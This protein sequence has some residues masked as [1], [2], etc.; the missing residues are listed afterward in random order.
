MGVSQGYLIPPVMPPNA[1]IMGGIM[2]ASDIPHDAPMLFF[3]NLVIF[4]Q[5][6]KK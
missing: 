1:P 2:G 3:D 6:V 4:H 5:I